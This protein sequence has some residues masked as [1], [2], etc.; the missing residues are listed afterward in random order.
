MSTPTP[1][2]TLARR[3]RLEVNMGSTLTPDYQLWPAVTNFQ[4]T[5]DP[6]I[7]D[8]STYDAGGW[9]DN[10]KTGQAWKVEATFNRKAT[11]DATSF[12]VVHEKV[13][14]AAFAFGSASELDVRWMDRD[15]LP[16]AYQGTSLVT[17]A[18][19]GGDRTALDAIKVTLTGKGV[20]NQIVNPL[21]P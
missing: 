2:T 21:A 8:S 3:W 12:S 20:L 7:Q 4:W 6:S 1:T 9:A 17:W 15:G 11:I 13:R 14:A 18:P 19:A 16:E 5:A 10:T